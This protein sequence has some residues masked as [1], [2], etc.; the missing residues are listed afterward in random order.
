[1]AAKRTAKRT[2]RAKKNAQFE[3]MCKFKR[4]YVKQE[5]VDGEHVVTVKAGRTEDTM[6]TRSKKEANELFEAAIATHKK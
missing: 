5:I 4:G 3:G 6:R 2:A 1:M